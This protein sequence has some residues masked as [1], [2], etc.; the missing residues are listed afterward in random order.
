MPTILPWTSAEIGDLNIFMPAVPCL[1]VYSAYDDDQPESTV[2]YFWQDAVT[3]AVNYEVL[4]TEPV[5]LDEALARAQEQAA[6]R[7]IE[8]IH[9][10]H[11]K[12]G[13]AHRSGKAKPKPASPR[14]ARRKHGASRKP[15]RI[16][17]GVRGRRTAS[18]A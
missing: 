5:T 14:A 13:A 17:S 9:V 15:R 3:G 6:E 2:A 10:K 18:R 4:F 12:L 16:K 7:R 1:V 8:R 11:V